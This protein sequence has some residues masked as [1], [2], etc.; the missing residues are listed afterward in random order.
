MLIKKNKAVAAML[1]SFL[2]V[3]NAKCMWGDIV[4]SSSDDE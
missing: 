3:G 4:D 1:I 2:S